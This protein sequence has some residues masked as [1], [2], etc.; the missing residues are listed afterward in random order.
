MS[1]EKLLTTCGNFDADGVNVSLADGAP[2]W[3][4]GV[5]VEEGNIVLRVKPM[6]M[7]V[8]VR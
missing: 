2:K 3:A 6:P 7:S 8:I 1:G 4:Q 5:S